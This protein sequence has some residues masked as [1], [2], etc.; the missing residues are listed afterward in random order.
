MNLPALKLIA[1]ESTQ[2]LVVDMQERL[3]PAMSHHDRIIV[4]ARALLATAGELSIPVVVSEQYP[5]GLGHTVEALSEK[6]NSTERIYAK[7]AFSCARDPVIG[8]ELHSLKQ[9]GRGQVVILGVEAHVCVLQTAL[10]LLAEGFTV[11]VVADAVA[12][13]HALDLSCALERLREEG[14]RIVT[15]EMVLFEWLRTADSPAFKPVS[16][17]IKELI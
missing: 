15:T 11:F 6:L 13:R 9:Q 5:R 7:S 1:A 16:G 17:R 12:S 8:A 3:L 2:L 10:D 4:R 14:A